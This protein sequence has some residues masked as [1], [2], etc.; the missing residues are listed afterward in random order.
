MLICFSMLWRRRLVSSR[1]TTPKVCSIQKRTQLVLC[2]E[3]GSG[4]AVY[5]PDLLSLF[6]RFPD[7]Q[8]TALI[9]EVQNALF[10]SVSKLSWTH[11]ND[12]E[13]RHSTII[14]VHFWPAFMLCERQL[15]G[16]SSLAVNKW[17]AVKHGPCC[18]K[19]WHFFQT[20]LMSHRCVKKGSRREK[21]WSTKCLFF[22]LLCVYFVWVFEV[23]Q[24][25]EVLDLCL[26]VWVCMSV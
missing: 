9:W 1:Q 2:L 7:K 3:W 6:E 11:L 10:G 15:S 5:G 17:Q 26:Y 8:C 4:C 23:N 19:K 14:G 12:E 21:H 24:V 22:I 20:A 13:P 18:W 25:L 16:S